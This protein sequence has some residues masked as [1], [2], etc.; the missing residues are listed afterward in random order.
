MD[1]TQ[2]K[3]DS[4]GFSI[5]FKSECKG[6]LRPEGLRAGVLEQAGHLVFPHL[7]RSQVW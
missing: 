2:V 5:R 4:L 6:V 1:I 7:H 3:E